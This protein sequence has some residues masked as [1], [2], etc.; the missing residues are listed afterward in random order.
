MMANLYTVSVIGSSIR[1][2]KSMI[3]IFNGTGSGRIVRCYRF[4]MFNNQTVAVAGTI[5]KFHIYSISASGAGQPLQ[6]AKYSSLSENIP[7]QISVVTSATVALNQLIRQVVWSNDEPTLTTG[8][9]DETLTNSL[10][11]VV[12]DTSQTSVLQ[13]I[14]LREG[15]GVTIYHAGTLAASV[16]VVDLIIEFSVEES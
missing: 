7:P 2:K 11:T 12:C 3:S 8:G 15:E 13:P 9:L 6:I 4:W 5:T 10:Y 16:G 14:T 1:F